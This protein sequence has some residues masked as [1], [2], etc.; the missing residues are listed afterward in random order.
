MTF[1]HDEPEDVIIGSV[2]PL[3]KR[4]PLG[5]DYL[6]LALAFL[7]Y[8]P[9]TGSASEAEAYTRRWVGV[10]Y[11]GQVS[12]WDVGPDREP[13]LGLSRFGHALAQWFRMLGRSLL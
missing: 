3:E 1:R 10:E 2:E 8:C 6:E 12:R 13:N 11:E 4:E 9:G 7:S 5:S